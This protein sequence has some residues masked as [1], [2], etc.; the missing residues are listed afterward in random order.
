MA[1]EDLLL[2]FTNPV[3]G[4]DNEFNE[5]YDTTHVRDVLA[6]PG[7][8]AARR[9]AVVDAEPPEMEGVPSPPPPDHRYLAV[10]RLE[11]DPNEVMEEFLARIT[12]G[13]MA[14]SETLDLTSVSMA[15]WSPRGPEHRT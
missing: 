9:Y 3:A 4:R 6:V 12:S 1:E 15:V 11:R 8:V 2:V 5:W 10:Y 7:V 14:L 13:A